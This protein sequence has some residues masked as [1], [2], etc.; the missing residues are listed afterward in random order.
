MRGNQAVS[1]CALKLSFHF[2]QLKE[3]AM[4]SSQNNP[5]G[6]VAKMLEQFKFPGIDMTAIIAARQK[7][8]QAVVESNKKAMEGMQAMAQKQTEMLKNAMLEIQTAS[9]NLTGDFANPTKQAEMAKNAYAKALADM[10]TLADIGQKAQA[11]SLA[12]VTK[13][14][15]ENLEE[16]KKLMTPK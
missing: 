4:P 6:D 16:I 15:S 8:I 5:F 14:A 1:H 9:K 12:I 11:E 3:F 2:A 13:R 10:K 7:D